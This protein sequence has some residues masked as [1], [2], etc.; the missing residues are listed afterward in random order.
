MR[1][2]VRVSGADDAE[3]DVDVFVGLGNV[4]LGLDAGGVDGKA[5]RGKIGKGSGLNA[6]KR[7][8][9]GEEPMLEDGA[10]GAGVAHGVEIEG[11]EEDVAGDESWVGEL[12]PD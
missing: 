12:G 8:K 11:G 6:G 7:L 1:R 10:G 9:F 3:V 4:A 5:E 2:V